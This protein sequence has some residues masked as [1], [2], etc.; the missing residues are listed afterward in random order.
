M[1]PTTSLMSATWPA[2]RPQRLAGLA[3]LGHALATCC[4]EVGSGP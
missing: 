2:M 1:S 3:D 4:V